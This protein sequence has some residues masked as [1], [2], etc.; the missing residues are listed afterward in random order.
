MDSRPYASIDAY[1]QIGPVLNIGIA[2]ILDVYGIEVQIQSLSDPR[3]STWILISRGHERFVN[4]LHLHNN[5]IVN[6]S[7]SLQGREKNSDGLNQDS[8]KPASGNPMQGLKGS[9]TVGVR[10]KSHPPRCLR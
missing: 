2:R 8:N 10:D 9:D 6:Q 7:F 1:Q 5:T 4:F 3:F